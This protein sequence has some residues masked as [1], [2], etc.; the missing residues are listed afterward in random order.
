MKTILMSLTI[1]SVAV[2]ADGVKGEAEFIKKTQHLD[3]GAPRG[4]DIQVEANG[5]SLTSSFEL[6]RT[7]CSL[8]ASQLTQNNPGLSKA[9]E[10]FVCGMLIPALNTSGRDLI[11]SCPRKKVLG[12]LMSFSGCGPRKNMSADLNI[13]KLTIKTHPEGVHDQFIQ[14]DYKFTDD[15]LY[16]AGVEFQS[17][18]YHQKITKIEYDG[19]LPHAIVGEEEGNTVKISFSK[20]TKN[21]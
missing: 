9:I 14:N 6:S 13:D 18:L 5:K 2:F 10:V 1:L 16:P 3:Y 17:S 7:S 12:P 8:T 20:C 4:C 21:H 15:K 11:G 19:S